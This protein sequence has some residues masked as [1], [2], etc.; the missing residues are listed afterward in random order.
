MNYN[1]PNY[2]ALELCH[3]NSL[4]IVKS[5]GKEPVDG[6]AGKI[7]KCDS[8]IF[9]IARRQGVKPNWKNME[10]D[11]VI[12]SDSI[13]YINPFIYISYEFLFA[14]WTLSFGRNRAYGLNKMMAVVNILN[15][16]NK[17]DSFALKTSNTAQANIGY[18]FSKFS[19]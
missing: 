15:K 17:N 4:Q 1:L 12:T 7:K 16:K 10:A 11:W 5:A 19:S 18:V 6:G 2:G 3:K 13:F 8:E 9:D 14:E